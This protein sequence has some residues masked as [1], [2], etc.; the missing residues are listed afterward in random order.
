MEVAG[1]EPMTVEQQQQRQCE[2]TNWWCRRLR[3]LCSGSPTC[4]LQHCY[5][6]EKPTTNPQP[7]KGEKTPLVFQKPR[8]RKHKD[9][10]CYDLKK[11]RKNTLVI[12]KIGWRKPRKMMEKTTRK[13][14][15]AHAGF[16]Q[17]YGG[18]LVVKGTGRNL[19]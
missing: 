7:K 1:V 15:A 19:E 14:Y 8:W 10:H 17:A 6:P 4:L 9:Q 11:P 5:A 16:T 2:G 18:A 3:M 13:P 12:Q